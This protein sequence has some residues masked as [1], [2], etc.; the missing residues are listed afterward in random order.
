MPGH[1]P[2]REALQIVKSRNGQTWLED[3]QGGAWRMYHLIPDCLP[4]SGMQA[5]I[6]SH[7]A[8]LLLGRFQIMLADLE[9]PLIETIPDF[10]N[11]HP[12]AAKF[13][14][15]LH[16]DPER[17]SSSMKEEID[18]ALGHLPRMTLY[19]DQVV[20]YT[21]IR[22]VHYDTKLNNFLFGS[23]LKPLCLID[24]DTVMP[25]YPQFDYGD[26]LRTMANTSA[27]DVA[28]LDK[29]A[30][31]WEISRKFTSGYSEAVSGLL[32]QEEMML[33]PYSPAYMAFLIGLRFLTDHLEGDPYYRIH[34]PGHNAVRARVQFKLV[35]E[36]E[37]VIRWG[38]V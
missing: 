26:A 31:D 3:H 5:D 7:D 23:D 14:E 34:Y 33:F 4:A 15:A 27:E 20:R 6:L 13:R 24:L 18:F 9:T 21:R 22:P 25:G 11:I 19:Y 1:D 37:R 29:V 35:R 32:T 2:E 8:G 16:S 17:R 36:I 38:V 30:F 28:E 12:R 10:H